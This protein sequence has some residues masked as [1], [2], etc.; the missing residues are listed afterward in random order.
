M[1]RISSTPDFIRLVLTVV[2]GVEDVVIDPESNTIRVYRSSDNSPAAVEVNAA[3]RRNSRN[4]IGPDPQDLLRHLEDVCEGL[5]FAIAAAPAYCNSSDLPPLSAS[6]ANAHDRKGDN[7]DTL[8][9]DG[10]ESTSDGYGTPSF[11]RQGGSQSALDHNGYTY[12]PQAKLVLPSLDELTGRNH[13]SEATSGSQIG[14][15]VA[16]AAVAEF[17]LVT[18][19]IET[20]NQPEPQQIQPEAPQMTTMIMLDVEGMMCQ[21]NCG[22]TVKKALDAAPG[23]SRSEVS[24]ADR[25]ARVW[26]RAG[27]M[28]VADLVDAVEAVGFGVCAPP[29]V[30]LEVD[31]MMCQK[32]CGSTV[33]AA[34]QQVPGVSRAEVSFPEK[35]AKVWGV[36]VAVSAVV[37]AVESVGFGARIPSDVVLDIGGMMCQ[38][39][40]GSTVSSALERVPGVARAEVSF[41]DKRAE[42]WGVVGSGVI[43][44]AHL[45]DAVEA[46]GFEARVSPEFELEL[47][48]MMCQNSCGATVRKALEKVSGV[49]RAEVSFVD[50]R[51][52]VW[53]NGRRKR[54]GGEMAAAAGGDG[55]GGGGSA[56]VLSAEVLVGAV[57]DVGF[58]ARCRSSPSSCFSSSAAAAVKQ[59]K[60]GVAGGDDNGHSSSMGYDSDGDKLPGGGGGGGGRGGKGGGSRLTMGNCGDRAGGEGRVGDS[61]ASVVGA[62]GSGGGKGDG[63]KVGSSQ[64]KLSTGTFTVEGMSCA[65]CVGKVERF[66]GAMRG[67]G[68][69]RVALLAG[70]VGVLS[71]E[72]GGEPDI[73]LRKCRLFAYWVV[74]F[75]GSYVPGA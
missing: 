37:D 55:S 41:A 1:I 19:R 9:T 30:E 35:R 23:V 59:P 26:G 36:G 13:N 16:A 54:R 64:G 65:A 17:D 33:K 60:S 75:V 40:C 28:T 34:L 3:G 31:G 56:G 15:A 4:G 49:V 70:Q 12:S 18:S 71:G 11:L 68:E 25:Q 57:E 66:V 72:G 52:R 24:F 20:D 8:L 74:C 67:V 53:G 46:I 73:V 14:T 32:S 45:V 6:H 44:T 2:E 21:K 10:D 43:V 69:V 27:V 42:V 29:D 62:G 39:N 38:K 47:E 48:G 7:G 63:V 61:R 58:E 5:T 22:S 50:K 51:A